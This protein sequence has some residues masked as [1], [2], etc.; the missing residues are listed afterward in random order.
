MLPPRTELLRR[1]G[2]G[3][4]LTVIALSAIRAAMVEAWAEERPELAA[5]AWP[6]HPAA[7]LSSSLSEIGRA[8]AAGEAPAS[9]TFIKVARAARKAPLASE[10]L[11]VA[12][13]AELSAGRLDRAEPLLLRARARDPRAIAPRVLLADLYL[14]ERRLDLGLREIAV[15][16]RLSPGGPGPVVRLLA[17]YA[18]EPASQ[19]P[20]ATLFRHRPDLRDPVLTAMAADPAMANRVLA[21]AGAKPPRGR[22]RAVLVDGLVRDGRIA[23]ARTAWARLTGDRTPPGEVVAADF[24]VQREAIPPFDWTYPT[25]AGIAEV[26]PDGLRVMAYGRKNGALASQ[27][28]ILP[29]G[30]HVFSS[31]TSQ[32]AG[33][34]DALHWTVTCVPEGRE[35]FRTPIATGSAATTLAVPADCPAQQLALTVSVGPFARTTQAT[36]RHI[37]LRPAPR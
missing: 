32:L 10:P 5:A 33:E 3:L 6:N 18:R 35:L 23:E 30:G 28:L 15:L 16:A 34:A 36:I 17:A 1:I 8:A 19:Q 24:R 29:P 12:G 20:L 21:L 26:R 2:T 13:T 37:V 14:R 4:A 25:D 7:L 27:L 11:L 9:A 31:S 22:W